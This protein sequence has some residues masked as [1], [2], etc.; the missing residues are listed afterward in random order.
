MDNLPNELVYEILSYN[1]NYDS[2][3]N[4]INRKCNIIFNKNN[5][6]DKI[7]KIIK[8]YKKKTFNISEESFDIKPN[9]NKYL[10]IGYFRKY[11]SMK[12]FKEYPEF[13]IKKL[14][15]NDLQNF[16]DNNL[17][18]DVNKRKKINLLKFLNQE[19]ISTNDIFYVGL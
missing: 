12:Y 9:T 19:S 14:K 10:V 11:Y 2:R 3:L 6:K 1:N 4:E 17:N 16:V 13:F 7:Y 8:W 5:Y 15:R 18:K